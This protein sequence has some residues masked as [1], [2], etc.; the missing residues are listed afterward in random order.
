MD[1]VCLINP[2]CMHTHA[3][4]CTRMHTHAHACTRMHTHAELLVDGVP[5]VCCEQ[6]VLPGKAHMPHRSSRGLHPPQCMPPGLRL[7]LQPDA[8]RCR[9]A[10]GAPGPACVRERSWALNCRGAN[11]GGREVGCASTCF[12]GMD[13]SSMSKTLLDWQPRCVKG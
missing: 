5:M 1:P 2:T 4:A 7:P 9:C 10:C 13:T 6:K 3:H 11:E 12:G 8:A